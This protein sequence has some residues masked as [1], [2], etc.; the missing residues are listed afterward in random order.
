MWANSTENSISEAAFPS[1]SQPESSAF[2]TSRLKKKEVLQ[3]LNNRLAHYF[4]EIKHPENENSKLCSQ[5]ENS[6][7]I[8]A[9]EISNTEK[10]YK[11]KLSDIKKLIDKTGLKKAKLEIQ[12]RRLKEDR[13]DYESR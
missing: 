1:T 7:G 8:I 2:K 9:Q 13:E 3:K 6:R 12:S 10:I 11:R 4:G 5:L